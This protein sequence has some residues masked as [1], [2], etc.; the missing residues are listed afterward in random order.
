MNGSAIGC[1]P[2]AMIAFWNLIELAAAV[3]QRHF[4]VMRVDELADA[5]HDFDLA[6]LGHAG[7]AAG[8]LADDL[9]LVRAQ[10]VEVDARRRETDAAVGHVLRFVHHAGDVQQ[11]FRRDAADVE[12]D[13]AER[14]VALDEDR[15]HAEV[16]AAESRRIAARAG[17]EDEHLA[18]EVGAAADRA[19][20][21]GAA[22]GAGRWL[23]RRSLAAGPGSCAA[24]AAS[25][26]ATTDPVETLSPSLTFISLTTPATLLG[27]S[28]VALS[29][30]RVTS[31]SSTLTVSPTATQ[32]SITG[33][34]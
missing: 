19:A 5:L 20:A 10:A 28:I 18:L 25:I 11:R 1:E 24:P 3:G 6:P 26:S 4:D 9:V 7:E 29:D 30:S 27:T 23:A 2:A 22:G 13:A 21:C 32:R 17:A 14:R 8:Q 16:G 12:A 31:A 15:L 33:M 34:S